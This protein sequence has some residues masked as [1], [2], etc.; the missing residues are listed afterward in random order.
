MDDNNIIIRITTEAD[1]SD[2]QTQI[3]A[4][5]D[6]NKE[7]TAQLKRLQEQEKADAQ[8]IEATVSERERLSAKLAENAEY[9]KRE[10]GY[11]EKDIAAGKQNIKMLQQSVNQYNALSGAGARTR[12]QLMALREELIRMA[13]AG[14]TT[15]ER[16]IKLADEAS[17]LS[18]TIGDAQSVI[19]L[20]ASDTKNLDAAM[21]VGGGLVGTFNAATSAMALLGGESE[22]LQQAFLKVQ[23]A[24]ALLNGVQQVMN[25][26]DKR[27]A[28]NVV[29]RTAAIKLLNKVKGQQVAAEA[30]SAAT[31]T[32]DTAAQVTNTAAV[33][34]STIAIKA[35][36]VAMTILN[37][38]ML[39][40]PVMWLIAGLAALAAGI[41]FYVSKAKKA[42]DETEA[43]NK[44]MKGLEYR[45]NTLNKQTEYEAQLAEAQGKSWQEVW[46]IRKDGAQQYLDE[47]TMLKN[48]VNKKWNDTRI[49]IGKWT[50]EDE[51]NRDEIYDKYE[52]ALEYI[53]YLQ[54]SY[55]IKKAADQTA[56]NNKRKE[57]EE[58]AVKD[59]KA[60][61]EQADKNAAE[62]WEKELKRQEEKLKAKEDLIAEG[63]R[64]SS[65]EIESD[66]EDDDMASYQSVIDYNTKRMQ[67]DGAT[68]DQIYQYRYEKEMAYWQM[69]LQQA[70]FGSQQ[71]MDIQNKIADMEIENNNRVMNT[72]QDKQATAIEIAMNVLQTLGS[73]A[74]EIFG[75]ISDNIQ[76]QIDALDDMYTTDAEEAKQDAN[77]KY[78]S[79]KELEE[80]KAKLKLRQQKL[81]K[82]NAIFQIGLSTAMAIMSIW[83]QVP[84]VDFGATTIALTAA[85]AAL[86]AT[87]LAIAAAKPLSQYEKGRKGGAGEYALVGEKGP[88]VM[89]VPH[90]A[91]IIPNNKINDISAWGA[92][93]V[94][95]IPIPASANINNE[96]LTQA[97][98]ESQ[99]TIDYTRLGEALAKALPKQRAVNVNIDR[100]G[101]SVQNGSDKRTYLNTKYQ[102]SW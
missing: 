65:L 2:A 34:A 41:T 17:A 87:Q 48:K 66:K 26:L 35:K 58:Q 99:W 50:K 20:L 10:R 85:A 31:T 14:D 45:Q 100:S 98:A 63:K 12:T 86:G 5:T 30:A 95:Q 39:A 89:Y 9:Y 79:E 40:N 8:T 28:A 53:R 68:E 61:A 49:G 59:S 24:I 75:A 55:D 29:I 76:A 81:D 73:M 47:V 22:E 18:D 3:G 38:T 36:N 93:G 16:F 70:E 1:L 64:L 69:K 92:Y 80:K 83:A 7:L 67:L 23:A 74:T 42:K 71:Y 6:R 43:W 84:K 21:Q 25:V 32:T 77:K 60:A 15:S 82:A 11:I 102:G 56:Y 44:A 27:S 62:M 13:E 33:N 54:R 91:S 94:P 37:K 4:L 52:E 90:G 19:S 101:I 78:L 97:V 46:Q 57:L 51:R 96:T 88:E 72:M